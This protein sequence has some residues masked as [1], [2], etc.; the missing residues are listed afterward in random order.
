MR[1]ATIAAVGFL[2][3]APARAAEPLRQSTILSVRADVG[4][5]AAPEPVLTRESQ[6]ARTLWQRTMI[7]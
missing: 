1:H 6:E 2:L 3:V 4:S 7:E 5:M